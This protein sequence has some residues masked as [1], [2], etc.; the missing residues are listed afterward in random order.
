[1]LNSYKILRQIEGNLLTN[2]IESY[3][4]DDY[5]NIDWN[6]DV[7]WIFWERWVWKTTIMLQK[8]KETKNSFYFSAD[9]VF[10]KSD[11]LFNFVFYVFNNFD[12]EVF[13][14]D[15]IFKYT[16]WKEELKNIIDSLPQ[17]KIIF[18]WSSSMA[19]Y[20]WVIDLWRRVYD[21]KINTLSF[22]EFLKMKYSINLQK[23]TLENIIKNHQNI[24]LD[25]SMQIK[26]IYF[27]EYLEKWAY[28]FWVNMW[29]D[30]FI[31]RLQKILD[32]VILED[33]SYIKNFQTK[34]L[35]KLSRLL[36]F[37]SQTSP[38]ELSI[39][40]LSK[41]VW[42][43]K[44]IV[45]SVMFLLSKIGTI[46]LVQKWDKLSEKIRKEYKIFLWDTNKYLIYNKEVEIWTIREAFFVSEIKKL[47]NIEISLPNKQ[48]FLVKTNNKNY[49][50]EVWWKNKKL[51]NKNI[52]ILKD[53]I[54]L[55]EE[56][57]IIPLWLFGFL[58]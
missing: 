11:G 30:S 2:K 5:Y 4:R 12:I 52:F 54:A 17:I 50:F 13:F 32:R 34:S 36:Y 43:D 45:D 48:D 47:K 21:Y 15:E 46:N 29:E 31:N 18:S 6:N 39:N 35:D 41:K 8:R 3:Y 9:N 10:I 14:I 56:K 16:F 27:K 55:S 38:S 26:D 58:N 28:P 44:N 53:N 7:I 57:N 40:Y 23:I 37:I 25:Y 49:I 51:N 19:L 24:S 22:R 20:N 1:M 33:L 42:V